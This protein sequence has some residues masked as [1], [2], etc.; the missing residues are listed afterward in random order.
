MVDK[1]LGKMALLRAHAVPP[2]FFGAPEAEAVVISWG[3][4]RQIVEEALERLAADG[5]K[6]AALHFG[7]VYP[8]TAEMIAPYRLNA[9]TLICVENN[10]GGQFAGLLKREFG[11]RVAH[12]I[13][14]YNGECFTVEEVH[15]RL[16]P[17]FSGSKT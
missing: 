3:S 1:R 7:Q 5:I 8:L 13:L 10:A 4:N 12:A 11:L 15:D 2:T 6:G 16:K 9:K 14:K 17:L